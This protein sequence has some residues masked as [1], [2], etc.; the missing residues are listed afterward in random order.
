M[1]YTQVATQNLI[2]SQM[3]SQRLD[4]SSKI[5]LFRSNQIAQKEA[6]IVT[7]HNLFKRL[8]PIKPQHNNWEQED[9][10]HQLNPNSPHT[11]DHID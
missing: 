5:L 3:K 6:N 10:G 4:F 9:G 2:L 1:R 8:S 7:F 11:F